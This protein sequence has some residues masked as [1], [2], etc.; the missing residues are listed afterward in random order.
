VVVKPE[1]ENDLKP[2]ELVRQNSTPS[3]LG[4]WKE[5]LKTIFLK[6]SKYLFGKPTQK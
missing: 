5:N 2:G 3:N 6:D 4:V 1:E